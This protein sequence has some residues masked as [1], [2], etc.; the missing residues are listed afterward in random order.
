MI[1]VIQRQRVALAQHLILGFVPRHRDEITRWRGNT[2]TRCRGTTYDAARVKG[3]GSAAVDVHR[4]CVESSATAAKATSFEWSS[5][6]ESS[7]PVDL[8][9]IGVFGG[10]DAF[11][12]SIVRSQRWARAKG[13]AELDLLLPAPAVGRHDVKI[14]AATP[15]NDGDEHAPPGSL[16]PGRDR[17]VP[18]GEYR[19]DG[20]WIAEIGH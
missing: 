18:I 3:R 1:G 20:I 10:E 7:T 12:C 5:T 2:R 6:L 11:E 13:L 15:A 4:P 9:V 8:A 17:V 14:G 19:C 16:A